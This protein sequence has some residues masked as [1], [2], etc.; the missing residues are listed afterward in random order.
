MGPQVQTAKLMDPDDSANTESS[1]NRLGSSYNLSH[2]LKILF[3]NPLRGLSQ[4]KHNPK[5]PSIIRPRVHCRHSMSYRGYRKGWKRNTE[6]EHK[7]SAALPTRPQSVSP[8]S[9]HSPT[10]RLRLDL[11][12]TPP[13]SRTPAHGGRGR[14]GTEEMGAWGRGA[15]RTAMP[16]LLPTPPQ[17]PREP[18]QTPAGKETFEL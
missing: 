10:L 8:S 13:V 17:M 18:H 6:P 5:K 11:P 7:A 9:D 15:A 2:P 3:L 16:V 4:G 1:R 14:A 12:S